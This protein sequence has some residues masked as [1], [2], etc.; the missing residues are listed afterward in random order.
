[1]LDLPFVGAGLLTSDI[2]LAF[3]FLTF[4]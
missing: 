4:R 1:M 2:Q 3:T